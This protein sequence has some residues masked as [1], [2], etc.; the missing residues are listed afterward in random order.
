MVVFSLLEDRD[1]IFEGGPYF[2]NSAGL[3]M[4]YWKENFT[5]DKEDFTRVPVWIR[6]YSLPTNYWA[7]SVLKAIGDELREYI[8]ISEDTKSGHY[9]S[10][11]RICAYIDVS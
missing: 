4:R 8:Q 5:P 6:L 10:Y 7:S 1:R 2:F 9:I 11:A 3:Y